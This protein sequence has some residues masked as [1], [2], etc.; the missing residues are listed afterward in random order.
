MVY[1]FARHVS[2]RDHGYPDGFRLSLNFRV[3]TLRD[4]DSIIIRYAFV[5]PESE[6][7]S[8]HPPACAAVKVERWIDCTVRG[9]ARRSEAGGPRPGLSSS[10]ASATTTIYARLCRKKDGAVSSNLRC[11]DA[12]IR[13]Q[14]AAQPE[15]FFDR[16]D[17]TASMK[18]IR[19]E[20]NGILLRCTR[21]RRGV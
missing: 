4:R 1:P 9:K 11:S 21:N 13:L 3:R 14:V 16:L 17:K 7:N 5:R 19:P 18:P 6:Q 20:E 12:S 15:R 8:S 10:P 2:E